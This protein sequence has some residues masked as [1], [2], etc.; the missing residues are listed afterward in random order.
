[1]NKTEWYSGTVRKTFN[2]KHLV[3]QK[4]KEWKIKNNI[5]TIDKS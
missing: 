4:I 3:D 1:M 5:N 2:W